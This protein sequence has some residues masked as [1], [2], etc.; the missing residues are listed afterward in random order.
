MSSA[1]PQLG[2]SLQ[3]RDEATFGNFHAGGGN[4]AL[5]VA[6]LQAALAGDGARVLWLHGA[7]G[8]GRTHLLQALCHAAAQ[9]QWP[10]MYLPLADFSA[11]DPA[12]I[13]PGLE[14]LELVCLDDVQ[15]VL[16]RP[17]WEEALFHAMNRLRDA[18]RLLVLAA[19][20]PPQAL[21]IGLADLQS[22]FAAA[23][24]FRLDWPDDADRL[25]LLQQRA[26]LRGLSLDDEPARFL[27]ARAPR[28]TAA[29]LQLLDRLDHAALAQQRRLTLPFIKAVLGW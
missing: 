24:V 3:L 19:D 18:G 22:R 13:L 28:D 11:A 12:A 5:V 7:A 27:L 25:A 1:Y 2:L 16:G 6:A 15:A 21:A 17:A 20:K 10:A 26:T 9:R 29:L 4:N 14:A 8:S 23:T